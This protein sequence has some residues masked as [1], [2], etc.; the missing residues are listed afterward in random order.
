MFFFRTRLRLCMTFCVLTL[1]LPT[2]LPLPSTRRIRLLFFLMFYTR[3]H[4]CAF[5]VTGL[6]P[7]GGV[8]TVTEHATI[9]WMWGFVRLLIYP[10]L[11]NCAFPVTG[12][13]PREGVKTGMGNAT[14]VWTWGF[15][16][17][18]M[19]MLVCLALCLAL[20]CMT[21]SRLKLALAK[22]IPW[23]DPLSLVLIQGAAQ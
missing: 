10:P 1:V 23:G 2:L 16:P 3:L 13:S 6:S 17:L 11:N 18:S 19:I 12:L 7:R 15:N 9:A 4:N 8:K 20:V 14:I 21:S 5:P 22:G